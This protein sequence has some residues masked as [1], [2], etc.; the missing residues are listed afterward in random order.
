MFERGLFIDGDWI[1]N[2]EAFWRPPQVK[3]VSF[4]ERFIE[5]RDKADIELRPES[6]PF[7]HLDTWPCIL[8]GGSQEWIV[9]QVENLKLVGVQ[10]DMIDDYQFWMNPETRLIYIYDP[11]FIGG[12][13]PIQSTNEG[14][15]KP[16]YS[17]IGK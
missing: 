12:T 7:L 15:L 4:I 10:I 2:G 8:F 13:L 9:V 3:Q 14:K 1:S 16:A 11:D 17:D 5:D 6:R